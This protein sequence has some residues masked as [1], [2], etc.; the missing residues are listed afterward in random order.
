MNKKNCCLVLLL[1]LGCA[2]ETVVN[3]QVS[4]QHHEIRADQM[5][6]PF[7]TRSSTNPPF[8]VSQPAN[9]RLTVPPGFAISVFAEGLDDPRHMIEAPNGD[10]LVSEPGTAAEA[11]VRAIRLRV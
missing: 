1:A 9:A 11:R 10:V 5:P 8:V 7:A 6:V 3:A 2:R 4:L